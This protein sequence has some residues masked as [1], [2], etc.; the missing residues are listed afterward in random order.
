M[1]IHEGKDETFV[2]ITSNLA[3]SLKVKYIYLNP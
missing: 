1:N 3:T 2:Q